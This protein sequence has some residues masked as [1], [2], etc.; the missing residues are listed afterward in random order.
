MQPA[1]TPYISMVSLRSRRLRTA[2]LL[3]L[4]AVLAMVAYGFLGLM[5]GMRRAILRHEAR[6]GSIVHGKPLSGG[7]GAPVAQEPPQAARARRALLS[8]IV[9]SYAYWTLVVFLLIGTVIVAWLDFREVSRTYLA[10]RRDVWQEVAD[11][12]R[13]ESVPGEQR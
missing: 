2:G 3:L 6:Y 1:S 12:S 13:G 7:R 5:P 11:R 4:A 9:F 8:L 10:R